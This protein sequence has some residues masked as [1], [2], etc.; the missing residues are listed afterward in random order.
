[1]FK[2]RFLSVQR[3][4]ESGTWS[5]DV[6]LRNW[7]ILCH[8]CG[9]NSN[10]VFP[11][12]GAQFFRL[13]SSSYHRKCDIQFDMYRKTHVTVAVFVTPCLNS[14][15]L[16]FKDVPIR[17][18]QNPIHFLFL[19]CEQTRPSIESSDTRQSVSSL[20]TLCVYVRRND[21]D[22]KNTKINFCNSCLANQE[23]K[24]YIFC[25]FGW[26]FYGYF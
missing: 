24:W 1:M 17:W 9:R 3:I 21:I 16:R 13:I 19:S 6:R 20:Q 23:A 10:R 25:L 5:R 2:R 11:D 12:D 15:C 7:K 22:R 4:A 8:W 26:L 14:S 18:L